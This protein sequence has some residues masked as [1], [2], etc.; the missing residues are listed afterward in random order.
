MSTGIVEH[1]TA[2]LFESE[3]LFEVINGQRQEKKPMSAAAMMLASELVQCLGTFARQHKLGSAVMENLF[4]LGPNLPNR[5]PDVAFVSFSR[6]LRPEIPVEDTAAWDVVPNLAVEVISP[7]NTAWETVTKIRQ[8][9]QAGV[10]LVWVVYP[11]ERCVHV[12]D[13][14]AGSRIVQ[15]SDSLDGG[16]VLP[17]FQLS[18]KELFACLVKPS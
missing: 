3:R 4:R 10:Q 16:T 8:Y 14:P 15:E 17:G 13:S 6:W 2:G 12:Y 7:T 18:V 5:R 9:F 11:N 1:S